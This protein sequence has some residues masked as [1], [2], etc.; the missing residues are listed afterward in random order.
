MNVIRIQPIPAKD[1]AFPFIRGLA[2][3]F[4]C[5]ETM[6][7]AG[8][9]AL[10]E[11]MQE[12]WQRLFRFLSESLPPL[13]QKAMIPDQDIHPIQNQMK[14]LSSITEIAPATVEELN[15]F[16]RD[17]AALSRRY[18]AEFR[19]AHAAGRESF[20]RLFRKTV[21]GRELLLLHGSQDSDAAQSIQQTMANGCFYEVENSCLTDYNRFRN[22]DRLT[23]VYSTRPAELNRLVRA[24]GPA[25]ID[26]ALMDLGEKEWT[27][28]PSLARQALSFRH[29]EIRVIYRP[30]ATIRLLQELERIYLQ[31]LLVLSRTR[32]LTR[33]GEATVMHPSGRQTA[34]ALRRQV[35][36]T[37]NQS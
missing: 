12:E 30:F 29:S 20:R 28:H 8:R 36:P 5:V 23:A 1:L 19:V 33:G 34:G 26:V 32:E 9:T 25:A 16:C 21:G 7:R 3:I 37:F 2:G 4:A 18:K 11:S 27:Y 10:P 24:A 35:R 22:T 6:T 31:R 15:G 13:C 17:L 14:A